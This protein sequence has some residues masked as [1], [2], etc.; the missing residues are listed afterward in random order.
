MA[1]ADVPAA[2][3]VARAALYDG[4]PGVDDPMTTARGLRR[5][6]H[7][8]QTDPA[9]A[10]VAEAAD[11]ALVCMALALVREG[12][13]GLSLFGVAAE[14]RSRG[15][16]RAPLDAPFTTHG[17]DARG[18]L[19][20]SSESPAAMRR[21]ARLGLDLRPCVAAVGIPDRSRLAAPVALHLRPR[22]VPRR[23]PRPVAARRAGRRRPRRRR[24][25]DPGRRR[26]RPGGPR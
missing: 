10:W 5:I 17:A 25:R 21:Y 13:W 2:E 9:G 18:H 19:I 1:A 15:S 3:A 26:H 22:V 6:G 4:A 11:G 20:L 14:H 8:Q 24:R 7:L 23:H 12:I 16:A